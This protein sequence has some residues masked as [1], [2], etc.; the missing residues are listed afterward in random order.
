MS[1]VALLTVAIGLVAV[2]YAFSMLS[3][4]IYEKIA[5]WL[6][7]RAKMLSTGIYQMLGDA[8]LHAAFYAQPTVAC[9]SQIKRNR[10]PSYLSAQQFAG[11]V[12]GLLTAGSSV[13]GDATTAFAKM[14]HDVAALPDALPIKGAL[15][16][17]LSQAGGDYAKF[18]QLLSNWFDDQM[19]RVSGWYKRNAAFWLLIIGC[20]LVV[21]FNVDTVRLIETLGA[22]PIPIGDNPTPKDVYTA[23]FT[24]LK[25]GWYGEPWCYATGS[26]IGCRIDGLWIVAKVVGLGLS[27]LA[28]TL[29]AP[30]WFDVLQQL[31]NIR[32]AGDKPAKQ[33]PA[34]VKD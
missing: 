32:G 31:V 4:W 27:A 10:R 6:Q 13:A 1:I 15:I 24:A 20:V 30:F 12:I 16:S 11:A 22:N 29:G 5:S 28:L 18:V 34:A 33:Q 26:S 17:L 2:Y 9:A 7:L 19:D 3:S 21:A 25:F 8:A 23:V 14:R